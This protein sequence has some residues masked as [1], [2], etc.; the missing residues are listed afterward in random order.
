[1]LLPA[2]HPSLIGQAAEPEQPPGRLIVLYE[3]ATE[4][5]WNA[6]AG[7][8]RR[9]AR[10]GIAIVESAPGSEEAAMAALRRDPAVRHV[11]RDFLVRPQAAPNDPRYPEQWALH[12]IGAPTAWSVLTT[13]AVITVAVIDSGVDL[14]HPEFAGRILPGWNFVDKSANTN[15]DY[16]HG[17]H[18]AGIIA[19][20]GNNAIGVAGLAWQAMILPLKVLNSSGAGYGSDLILAID[21]AR[22][23]GARI[24]NISL[25]TNA[26]STALQ[27]AIDRAVAAGI[28]I[29]AAAGNSGA[30]GNAAVYPGA[31]LG[32]LSVAATDSNDRRAAFSTRGSM[33]GVAAPGVGVVST[34]RDGGYTSMSGTSM[35]SPMVAGLAALI[36]SRTPSLTAAQVREQILESSVDLGPAGR[37]DEFGAGRID[38]AAWARRATGLPLLDP[39]PT[40]PPATPTPR[41]S[42][43][44]PSPTRTAAPGYPAPSRPVAPGGPNGSAPRAASTTLYVPI[45]SR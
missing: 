16:G 15:D 32:V 45:A 28:L 13:T 8:K 1:L 38:A 36:W 17:T 21:A 3:P 24:V 14:T 30:S 33:V 23:R 19:A 31:S 5:H 34:Y 42:P 41:P 12:K 20:A 2:V 26:N 43:T 40:P 27:E 7:T 29:V 35:A 11:E 39:S 9:M 25:G 22:E 6:P 44:P 37:D 4:M 10:D 18:V